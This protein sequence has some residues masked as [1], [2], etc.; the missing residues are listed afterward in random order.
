MTSAERIRILRER[1]GLSQNDLA[2]KLDLSRSSIS[3]YETGE[4]IP[5]T[6]SEYLNNTLVRKLPT[7][8]LQKLLLFCRCI[9]YTQ[10]R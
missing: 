7:E 5:S 10:L 9:E 2:V 4:R 8:P 3:M 6:Y 1:A